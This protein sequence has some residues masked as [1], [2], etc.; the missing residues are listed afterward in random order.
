[1]KMYLMDLVRL[2]LVLGRER[3]DVRGECLSACR[4]STD[5][6]RARIGELLNS[7]RKGE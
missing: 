1:M 4:Q 5:I 2:V 6:A 3:R 7:N